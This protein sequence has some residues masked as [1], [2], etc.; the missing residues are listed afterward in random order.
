MAEYMTGTKRN[1]AERVREEGKDGAKGKKRDRGRRIGRAA[2]RRR[3]RG[4]GASAAER[5]QN[6]FEGE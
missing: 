4:R 6:S 1:A 3:R 5:E 2:G